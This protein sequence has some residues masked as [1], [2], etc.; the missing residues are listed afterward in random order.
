MNYEGQKLKRSKGGNPL[1]NSLSLQLWGLY[2][3]GKKEEES[4]MVLGT[5]V[6]YSFY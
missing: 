3:K 2:K 6:N 4:H 5:V 1:I